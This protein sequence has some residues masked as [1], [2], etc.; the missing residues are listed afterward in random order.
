MD[1]QPARPEVAL[2]FPGQDREVAAALGRAF[3]NDPLFLAI[4]GPNFDETER[5]RRSAGLF[6]VMLAGTRRHGQPVVGV[7]DNGRVA[8]AAIIEQVARPPSSL[9]VVLEGV[10]QVPAL[11]SAVG[12]DGFRRAVAA[13]DVL[14]KNR[15]PEPHLYL[16]VLGV[17]PPFQRRH[18]GIAILDYLRDQ[19]R[20]RPDLAG[21]YLETAT[22]ANVAYYTRCG[23]RVIGEFAPIGVRMWRMMQPR[24]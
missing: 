15:P 9:A 2:L 6:G 8:G 5:A 13:L 23:Y 18:F 14:L 10:A 22:E 12:F 4:V 7:L 3:I 21:V 19:T 1:N 20:Q 16:N 11:I 17:D 24:A